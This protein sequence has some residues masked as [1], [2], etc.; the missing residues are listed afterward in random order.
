MVSFY[1]FI[2]KCACTLQSWDLKPKPIR[3]FYSKG[4]Y[5][6]IDFRVILHCF[7]EGLEWCFEIQIFNISYTSLEKKYIQNN[8]YTEIFSISSN[9]L[10]C[11]CIIL[12]NI[13][14]N[15]IDAVFFLLAI[16]YITAR[17]RGNVSFQSK[18]LYSRFLQSRALKRRK[19]GRNPYLFY[20]KEQS[21]PSQFVKPISYMRLQRSC[22]ICLQ[23]LLL[24]AV[25]STWNLFATA[26]VRHGVWTFFLSHSTVT[27]KTL[28]FI[29]FSVSR[30]LVF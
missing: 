13:K 28:L 19:P 30:T 29:S 25:P 24:V 27:A 20:F 10:K 11:V 2:I 12:S 18:R 4:V 22:I 23:L 3:R 14:L 8:K 16:K 26:L 9:L 5:V 21:R 1:F 17:N 6:E 15:L 7:S